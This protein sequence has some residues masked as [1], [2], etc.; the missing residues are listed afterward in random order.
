MKPSLASSSAPVLPNHRAYPPTPVSIPKPIPGTHAPPTDPRPPSTTR[1][2]EIRLKA[3]KGLSIKDFELGPTLGTGTFGRV[4]QVRFRSSPSQQ[5][6][7]LK[8]LKKTEIV[9]LHQVEHIKWEKKILSQTSHPFI[10]QLINSFQNSRYVY[11]LLEY[12]PGGELFS[13]LRKDGRFSEDVSLFYSSEILLALRYLHRHKIVYR[14]LKPENLLISESGHVKLA[15]FGF[16]KILESDRTYTLC[17]TPEYLSPEII[18]G[19]KKG[20]GRSVDWW[21]FGILLYEM[22]VG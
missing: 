22:L 17:G 13:R 2:L 1:D 12:L 19:Q 18:K 15:D 14:D 3:E 11:M 16:A 21:A 6:F 8:M 10:V 4:R 20:Y 5:V 7:A 9:K